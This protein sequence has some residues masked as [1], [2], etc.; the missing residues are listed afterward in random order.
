MKIDIRQTVNFQDHF[1]NHLIL[2][3]ENRIHKYQN[4]DRRSSK[5]KTNQVVQRKSQSRER[6]SDSTW[7]ST[8]G[9][10]LSAEEYEH[11][12]YLMSSSLLIVVLMIL[13]LLL[14]TM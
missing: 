5:T 9:N 10:N 11:K 4:K 3:I 8:E 12:Q 1:S 14:W 13:A 2:K 6:E 7:T